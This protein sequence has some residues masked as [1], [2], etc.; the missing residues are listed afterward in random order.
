VGSSAD[1]R[2]WI[3]PATQVI[4]LKGRFAAPGFNDAHVHFYSGGLDLAS[5]QLRDAASEAEFRDRIRDFTSKLPAGRWVLG[6]NWDHETWT[7]ARLPTRQLIDSGSGDH[8]VFVSRLDGHMALANSRALQLAGIT[9]NTPDPPG[10]VI[11]K[12]AN[13]EPTGV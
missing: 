13:G 7:P 6:G 8:P 11:V 5:V 9:R 10:G 3:G 1:I 2:K 12:D 4:D